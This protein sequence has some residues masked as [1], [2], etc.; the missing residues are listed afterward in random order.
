MKNIKSVF[1]LFS[2]IILSSG[3]KKERIN[4]YK[5]HIPEASGDGWEVDSSDNV[6][7]GSVTLSKMMNYINA[8]SGHNIHSIL[9]SKNGKLVFEE[10]FEGYLCSWDPPGSNGD[11]I[12]Y[13]GETDHF[14]ASVSKSVT[15][16]LF[17]LTVK[18]GFIDNLD[19]K[20]VDIFPEY[21][22]ILTD[23]KAEITIKQLLTM[24]SGLAWDESSTSYEDPA[25][26][27]N[28]MFY[29]DDPLAYVLWCPLLYQPGTQF[30]YNSGGT[31][32]L[33]AI[34]E[35]YTGMSLLEFGNKYLFD[36]LNIE[37][38][39]WRRMPS[40][41]Y[42]ASSG[43]SLS[44][45]ELAKIGYIFLNNGYWGNDQIINPDW[46][47]ESVQEHIETQG[48]T[49]PL[50]YG[51]GYQWWLEDF[52]AN[53]HTYNSYFAAGWGDQYMFIFP[54]EKLII[55][56]TGGNYLKGGKI[57]PFSIVPDYIL[58]ALE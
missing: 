7:I 36:P 8:T 49:L 38:V 56:F 47:T 12:Q 33:G 14:P 46:I 51:Y 40:D 10:Y 39:E 34:I 58:S 53:D 22:D 30:L 23:A 9:I 50:A 5:Y 54:G 24:L 27:L 28:A 26:D 45:R 52:Q 42:F 13:D 41:Y 31:N 15:S 32:V 6:G 29:S 18:E 55:V 25:N 11:Y 37:E 3:C 17:G 19:K 20:V 57:S 43:L 16:V 2:L 35:K 44:P 48:R 4:E 1:L 21:K